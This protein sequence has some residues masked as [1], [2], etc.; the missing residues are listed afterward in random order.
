MTT[1]IAGRP[2]LPSTAPLP[3][4][5]RVQQSQ[6]LTHNY[7]QFVKPSVMAPAGWS[8]KLFK[9][10]TNLIENWMTQLLPRNTYDPKPIKTPQGI[11]GLKAT[12]IADRLPREIDPWNPIPNQDLIFLGI[13]QDYEKPV[14]SITIGGD[15]TPVSHEG[16][17]VVARYLNFG[18]SRYIEGHLTLADG[19]KVPLQIHVIK[20]L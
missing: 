4:E 12:G 5:Q 8:R 19:S 3:S 15:T 9:H 11:N 7:D 1:P 20:A 16:D 17:Q 13:E 2:P 6:Q 18:N 10:F 14:V